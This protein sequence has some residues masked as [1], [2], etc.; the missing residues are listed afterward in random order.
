MQII[1]SAGSEYNLALS[2]LPQTLKALHTAMVGFI[3]ACAYDPVLSHSFADLSAALTSGVV[4]AEDLALGQLF[5]FSVTFGDGIPITSLPLPPTVFA[6]MY[7]PFGINASSGVNM[8]VFEVHGYVTAMQ[9]A[10]GIPPP[11][12]PYVSNISSAQALKYFFQ[13]ITEDATGTT[14]LRYLQM[15]DSALTAEL[16]FID[17]AQS[18]IMKGYLGYIAQTFGVPA[19]LKFTIGDFLNSTASGLLVK[20]SAKEW[21][22]GFDDPLLNTVSPNGQDNKVRAVHS[23]RDINTIDIDHVPWGTDAQTMLRAGATPYRLK[24]GLGVSK[25]NATTFL[26]RTDGDWGN[27]IVYPTTNHI[28]IV[29]GKQITVGQYEEIKEHFKNSKKGKESLFVPTVEAW[30]DIG[31]GLDLRRKVTLQHQEGATRKKNK[32]VSTEVYSFAPK[33]FL[34]CPITDET[35]CDL[36]QNF[37]GAFNFSG[38]LE[39]ASGFYS[40][41]HGYQTDF[42]AFGGSRDSYPYTSFSPDAKNHSPEFEIYARTGNTVGMKMPLQQNFKI[43]PTDTFYQSIWQPPVSSVESFAGLHLPICHLHLSYIMPESFF[44]KIADTINHI[45]VM[46]V[47]YLYVMPAI[48]VCF[49]AYSAVT[50]YVRHQLARTPTLSEN[51]YNK[52]A[53]SSTSKAIGS[54]ND[55]SFILGGIGQKSFKKNKNKIGGGLFRNNRRGRYA[56][57]SNQNAPMEEVVVVKHRGGE[58]RGEFEHQ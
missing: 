14:A 8:P 43:E 23:I 49:I 1:K 41:P 50:L 10:Q 19:L 9:M 35:T 36:N 29:S 20:R 52:R 31:Q 44:N 4:T 46:T 6:P 22:F 24:T 3:N 27:R 5:S 56:D 51:D 48:S 47:I 55:A 54:F 30:A 32:K 45:T 40:L 17:D 11:Y 58:D 26:R 34:N 12:A 42:R 15:P 37:Y 7:E 33:T 28:E 13:N 57:E 16:G 53:T 2:A 25:G 38:F 18:Q 39:G 21:I